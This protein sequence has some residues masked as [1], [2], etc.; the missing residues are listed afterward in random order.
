MFKKEKETQQKAVLKKVIE[1][2]A[3]MILEAD[4]TIIML[5]SI[6]SVFQQSVGSV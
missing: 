6:C 1:I 4:N 2:A 5:I 3:L